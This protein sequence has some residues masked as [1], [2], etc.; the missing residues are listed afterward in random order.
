MVLCCG[1]S[2]AERDQIFVTV[3]GSVTVSLVISLFSYDSIYGKGLNPLPLISM[4]TRVA[5]FI[6]PWPS[7]SPENS[8]AGRV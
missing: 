2:K 8:S 3:D 5:G 4:F 1:F 6:D 7:P